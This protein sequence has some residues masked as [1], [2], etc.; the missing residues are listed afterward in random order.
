MQQL[1]AANGLACASSVTIG[2]VAFYGPH[3]ATKGS[4]ITVCPSSGAPQDVYVPPPPP[5]PPV[6]YPPVTQAPVPPAS[7]S[8]SAQPTHTPQVKPQPK[9]KPTKPKPTKSKPR[10]GG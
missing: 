2:N 4:T 7:S 6:Y 3:R 10:R 5:P 8:S 1:D 9:P